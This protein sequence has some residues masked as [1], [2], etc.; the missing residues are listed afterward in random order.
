IVLLFIAYLIFGVRPTIRL[1]QNYQVWRATRRPAP[2]AR[3]RSHFT[4]I[5]RRK[6]APLSIDTDSTRTAVSPTLADYKQALP[7]SD[8]YLV[9]NRSLDASILL[10]QGLVDSTTR[11]AAVLNTH[12]DHPHIVLAAQ[13]E[14]TVA[15]TRDETSSLS[16]AS[17]VASSCEPDPRLVLHRYGE[18]DSDMASLGTTLV[19]SDS[20][21]E[22]P[23][24][25]RP[26]PAH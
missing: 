23:R 13:E 24:V 10:K 19:A 8:P 1:W 18:A 5:P 17:S 26:P 16:S 7:F 22:V 21:E 3:S 15:L 9:V 6:K 20:L 2:V 14:N 25:P 11:P 4:A 12:D